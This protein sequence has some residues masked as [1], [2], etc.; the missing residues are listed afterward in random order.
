MNF[1]LNFRA[2]KRQVLFR[3]VFVGGINTIFGFSFFPLCYWALYKILDINIIV[4]ISHIICAFFAFITHKHITFCS[5]G[6]VH[7]EVSKFLIVHIVNWGINILLLNIALYYLNW[8]AFIIQ[9][10]IALLLAVANYFV[11]KQFIF[12]KTI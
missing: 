4:T 9:L 3:Y 7:H 2:L 6:K 8:G 10:I 5:D 12:L 1:L 11:L